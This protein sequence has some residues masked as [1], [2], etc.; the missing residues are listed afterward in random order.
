[1]NAFLNIIFYKDIKSVFQEDHK[2]LCT[3]NLFEKLN[4]SAPCLL[5][6]NLFFVEPV[7]KVKFV[8]DLRSS[9]SVLVSV[10]SIIYLFLLLRPWFHGLVAL[11][12]Q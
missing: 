4:N 12:S 6:A 3:N 10:Q 9:F 2:L 1:M 8:S 7:F 5:I 11:C